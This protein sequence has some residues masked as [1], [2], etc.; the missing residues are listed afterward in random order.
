MADIPH[1]VMRHVVADVSGLDAAT[2][3][4]T[5]AFVAILERALDGCGFT[6]LQQVEHTFED[7]GEGFTAVVL[8]AESHAAVHTYP[9]AGYLALDVCTCGTRDPRDVLDAVL[10]ELGDPNA[11]VR[12]LERRP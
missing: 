1:A 10:R 12:V 2:L 11:R 8:L 4:D 3:R 6:R 7:G 9:E 5:T